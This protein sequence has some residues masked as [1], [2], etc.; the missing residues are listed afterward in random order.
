MQ[1]TGI[2]WA[3]VLSDDFEATLR[4]FSDVLGLSL[5]YQDETKELVHFRFPSGQLLEVY[6]PSNRH[7]KEKYQFFKGPVLGF[8]VDNVQLA[9]QEM[10][11]RGARFITELESWEDDMWTLFL[12]PQ[13]RLFEILRAARSPASR[14]GS[15]SGICYSR[16]FV[17]DFR[18]AMQF[19]SQVME[20]FPVQQ[21]DERK[22]AHYWLPTGQ[23]FEVFGSSAEQ[24][25]Q[26]PPLTIGFQVDNMAQAQH[27]MQSR[28]L[29]FIDSSEVMEDGSA[30]S[31]F[32]AP[33]GFIYELICNPKHPL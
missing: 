6:G 32:R 23:V 24:G 3:G 7:R 17:Q 9:R 10:I 12:G 33:D 19:F 8:E 25:D 2:G 29:E 16:F 31:Q 28:G 20:M 4:F 27:E 21:D 5:V 26:I 1:V 13:D 14:S 18:A 11:A 30:R 15:V 22:R